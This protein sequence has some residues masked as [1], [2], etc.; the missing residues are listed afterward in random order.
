ML[1]T[2]FWNVGIG[3]IERHISLLAGHTKI[4]WSSFSK[5]RESI[6][7]GERVTLIRLLYL[8]MSGRNYILVQEFRSLILLLP[9]QVFGNKII[10]HAPVS[11]K[12]DLIHK[13][14]LKMAYKVFVSTESEKSR[15][16]YSGMSN[17]L[18]VPIP[19]N[20]NFVTFRNRRN[21]EFTLKKDGSIKLLFVGRIAEQKGV[22]IFLDVVSGLRRKGY[23]V[24]A[25]IFGVVN[26]VNDYSTKIL[27]RITSENI[28][29]HENVLIEPQHF[30]DA[31][32]FLF[33]SLYEGYGIVLVEAVLTGIPILASNCKHGP[34]E[35]SR[36]NQL[37]TCLND[38]ENPEIWVDF[39]EQNVIFNRLNSFE[40]N[41][42]ERYLEKITNTISKK[43]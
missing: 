9:F 34:I 19:I 43:Q 10:F 37:F 20:E 38:Y 15:N 12:D 14:F 7:L 28:Q 39:L 31:D 25:E 33:P 23:T 5:N 29:Y 3:G 36:N 26:I 2:F 4:Y 41:C 13:I 17:V 22:H 24:F 42:V 18:Q 30:S 40:E 1:I 6:H 8:L 11:I 16:F 35:I 21:R 27:S 32:V